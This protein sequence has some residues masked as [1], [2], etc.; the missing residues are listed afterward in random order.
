MIE[1]LVIGLQRFFF[2]HRV[3]TLGVL[4]GIA[5]SAVPPALPAPWPGQ[6]CR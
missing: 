4:L 5:P 2:G 3:L 6:I 1:K